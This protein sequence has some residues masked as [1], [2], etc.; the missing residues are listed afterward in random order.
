MSMAPKDTT[1]FDE[2]AGLPA[3]DIRSAIRAGRYSGQTAGLAMGCLQ[4]NLVI[5]HRDNAYDFIRYCQR[6][7]KPCPLV[8][9]SDTGNA[10]MPSLGLDIDIRTDI[11]LYNI[12]RHG[13]LDTQVSDISEYW[14]DDSVAFVL[15][16]SFS[17]EEALLA[18]GI[19]LRHID[20]GGTVPMYRTN[21][22]TAP[23][24][25]FSGPMVVSMRPLS[26]Q[27]AVRASVVTARYPHAHGCP[28]H[29]GSPEHIGISDLG[30]PDWGDPTVF[31]DGE[32]PVFWACGVTPQAAIRSADIELCI[33]HAPGRM[34]IADT[35]SWR[36]PNT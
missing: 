8:G 33:T 16:C 20:N 27:D 21:I 28:I 7:P 14:S 9:V 26:S 35:P 19:G 10:S 15:G 22:E 30:E 25:P 6:N 1:E 4:G 34:L 18:E 23:S 2:L 17:F 5:L 32:L 11:P 36:A 29:I 31:E 3:V 12:Y 24:G 13:E